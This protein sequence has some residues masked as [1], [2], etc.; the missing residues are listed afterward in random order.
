M[1]TKMVYNDKQIQIIETA[2]ELFADRGYDGT[3]VRDIADVAGINVAMI[4]YY[5]GS[6]EKL[7]EALFEHRIGSIQMRVE[8]LLKDDSL[9]PFEKVN[10]LIDDHVERV[11]QKQCFHKI[12]I[13]VVLTNKMPGILKAAN[14]VK[15]R[16]AEIVSELIKDGQKKGVFKKKVD[17]ILMLNTMV[18]TVSQT[19]MSLGYYRE[20][21]KQNELSDEEFLITTKRKLSIHIKT[22]FKVILTNEA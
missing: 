20:F 13:S 14:D 1:V 10:M 12:M 21:N 3:S 11:M 2:E 18:G 17:V 22:L 5:F 6:K 19:L 16:I 4:S 15:L 8:S 7:M 9:T